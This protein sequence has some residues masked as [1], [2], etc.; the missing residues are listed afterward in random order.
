MSLRLKNI[1]KFLWDVE[2]NELLKVIF[3]TFAF[4]LVI[5]AYTVA[6]ELKDAI[7]LHTVGDDRK[8]QAFAKALSMF[9]LIPTIFFHSR[10]VDL[11]RKHQLLYIYTILYGI[12]GLL[13]V[14]LIGHPVIGLSNTITS[15]D[16]YFGWFFYFFIEGYS[17]LVV[18]VFWAF[19]NSIT[20]P[21]SA[22]NNYTIMI[23]GS[24]LG[25]IITA[26]CAIIL[27]RMHIF[28]DVIN[29]QILLAVSSII[30]LI[31]PIVIYWFIRD[32]PNKEL[33]GYEAAYQI[34]KERDKQA[35]VEPEFWL[36]SILSGLI[37]VFKY[38]Y[39]MGIF[40]MSFFFEL[41]NQALKVEGLIFGKTSA[42]TMSGFTAFLLGQA[43]LVHVIGFF[44]VVFGTRAIL[45]AIGERR[46][47]ML[48]PLITGVAVIIFILYR[49]YVTAIIAFVITRAVNYAFAVPVRESLYIPTIKEVRFKSKSW[50][51]GIGTKF[52]KMSASTYNVYA[53]GLIGQ[54]LIS[55][56][57]IF[58]SISIGLW[59]VTAY[60]LGRRFERA[61][62]N[63]EVIGA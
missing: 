58:F 26:A 46:S 23:A 56:H 4:F 32:V 19:A 9:V 37:M 3:L 57:T 6:R 20:T 33:H 17:P 39:V 34:E 24:K 53:D 47:L 52:A 5:G 38:P 2:R 35:K 1:F 60:A 36:K 21:E 51:D 8:Y 30:L 15:A 48:I 29:H 44:V 13:C 27:L 25:G 7:F 59:F 31:V 18:S 62:E 43:L 14:Y 16:R 55:A 50:I 54:A 11:L 22:K 41:I 45:Q 40:G 49:S 63:N 61:V 12:I 28:S 42:T 10:L